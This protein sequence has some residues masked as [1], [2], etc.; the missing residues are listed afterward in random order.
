MDK[1]FERVYEFLSKMDG[2]KGHSEKLREWKVRRR[3]HFTKERDY[4]IFLRASC[5]MFRFNKP[6]NE[7]KL[8]LALLDIVEKYDLYVVQCKSDYYLTP[9]QYVKLVSSNL[10]TKYVIC[11]V[12]PNKIEIDLPLLIS[13]EETK[14]LLRDLSEKLFNIRT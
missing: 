4:D 6:R 10:G 1:E 9:K 2:L 11:A 14:N 13:K 5:I 12:C 3:G 7:R 8:P